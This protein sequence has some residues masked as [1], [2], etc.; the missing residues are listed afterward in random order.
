MASARN[1]ERAAPIGLDER[2]QRVLGRQRRL[3]SARPRLVG[4]L[5]PLSAAR[6]CPGLLLF[7][8]AP[9]LR[10]R[11]TQPLSEK[12]LDSERIGGHA[13]RVPDSVRTTMGAGGFEPP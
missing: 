12:P 13:K 8:A 3:L 10:G 9:D 1:A 2:S 5:P 11:G 7:V 6:L 4:S